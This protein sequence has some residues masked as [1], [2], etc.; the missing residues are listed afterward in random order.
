MIKGHKTQHHEHD[1]RL[2][3]IEGQVRGVR[4]M[5]NEG[6]YCIDII[7]Q[8]EAVRSAL[9]SVSSRILEKHLSH[10]VADAMRGENKEEAEQKICEILK[11]IDLR[12]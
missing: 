1:A 9:R 8:I 4:R 11:I 7:H 3:R 2:A 12:K 10:C 6:E 5:V